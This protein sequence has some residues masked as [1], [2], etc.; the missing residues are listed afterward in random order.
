MTLTI[1]PELEEIDAPNHDP[2]ESGTSAQASGVAERPVKLRDSRPIW[3][4]IADNMKKVPPEDL[5]ALPRD[6]A[7]QIDHYIYGFP[8]RDQ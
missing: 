2:E 1:P 4:V 7:S 3:D 8:K 6:G 5:A